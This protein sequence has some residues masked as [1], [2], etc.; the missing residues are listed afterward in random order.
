MTETWVCADHHF[1]HRNILKF[2][3]LSRP[4]EDVAQMNEEIVYRHNSVVGVKD[5]VY[6]LGDLSFG[7]AEPTLELL[8]Q[9]NGRKFF[10]F[11]NHDTVMRN[12]AI[13][14]EFTWMKDYYKLKGF[15]AQPIVLSHF[16]FYSWDRMQ[17]GALHFYGH[18]HGDIP[19]MF[20]GRG[21]DVGLDTNACYPLNV[22]ELVEQMVKM[23]VQDARGR[24][25][26]R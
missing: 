24:D 25:Q 1:F 10:I 23:P 14:N 2:C 9:M 26:V 4:F 15:H 18:T 7:K 11:G 19:E 3:P 21:R 12:E 13:R 20:G 6:F 5:D 8:S 17:Y 16:P 22:R